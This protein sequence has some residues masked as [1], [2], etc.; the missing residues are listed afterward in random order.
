MDIKK[1]ESGGASSSSS[2]ERVNTLGKKSSNVDENLDDE[3]ANRNLNSPLKPTLD[4]DSIRID[5]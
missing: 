4:L 2:S 1:G 5:Q 3:S